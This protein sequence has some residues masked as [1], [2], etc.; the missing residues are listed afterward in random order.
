MLRSVRRTP[1]VVAILSVLVVAGAVFLATFPQSA[2]Q[3]S[4][5]PSASSASARQVT[6]SST[7]LQSFL[8]I[9]D[10]GGAK[11]TFC[12]STASPETGPQYDFSC[13]SRTIV[14]ADVH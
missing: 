4:A 12:F 1:K 8:W 5:P 14:E 6:S 3:P 2:S 9:L 7:G 13:R 10:G 11:I